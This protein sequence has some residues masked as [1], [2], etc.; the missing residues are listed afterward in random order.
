MKKHKPEKTSLRKLYS[1]IIEELIRICDALWPTKNEAI[2]KKDQYESARYIII[3][4]KDSG[5]YEIRMKL[6]CLMAGVKVY[7]RRFKKDW[8]LS[9]ELDK[10]IR[11]NFN[12]VFMKEFLETL[13]L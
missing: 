10:I 5:I 7:R 12:L 2:F 1:L 13:P 11:S 6:F 3:T 4:D 9:P 8:I